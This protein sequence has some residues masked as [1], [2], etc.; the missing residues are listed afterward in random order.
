[1]KLRSVE[2]PLASHLDCTNTKLARDLVDLSTHQRNAIDAAEQNVYD[3]AAWISAPPSAGKM[4]LAIETMKA[5]HGIAELMK[6]I[7]LG[8][9]MVLRAL[10][11]GLSCEYGV[12]GVDESTRVDEWTSGPNAGMPIGAFEVMTKD[13][14]GIAQGK[15]VGL[16]KWAGLEK[17]MGLGIGMEI[18]V[19]MEVLVLG[20]VGMG[21]GADEET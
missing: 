6:I 3:D 13:N 15:W 19:M 20:V 21:V 12:V 1:M 2:M 10:G 16:G 14:H 18:G 5:G 17:W 8:E 7:C 4:V 9:R 11:L